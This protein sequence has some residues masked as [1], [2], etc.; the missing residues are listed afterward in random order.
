MKFHH[1]IDDRWTFS[2][3]MEWETHGPRAV[4]VRLMYG[5]LSR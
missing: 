4:R 1:R 5:S 3:Q 2:L